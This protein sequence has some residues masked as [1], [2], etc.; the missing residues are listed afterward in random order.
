[1][2]GKE[3]ECLERGMYEGVVGIWVR[4]MEVVIGDGRRW[5]EGEKGWR[6][7]GGG[8]RVEMGRFLLPVGT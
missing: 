8:W 6:V 2:E 3:G 5:G 7:E 1:M 4:G